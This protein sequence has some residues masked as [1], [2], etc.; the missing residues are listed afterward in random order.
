MQDLVSSGDLM[1]GLGGN[2]ER[3][4]ALDGLVRTVAVVAAGNDC[5]ADVACYTSSADCACK[6]CRDADPN[7]TA[8]MIAVADASDRKLATTMVV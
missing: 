1:P 8:A 3:L 5:I 6:G 4:V 7:G 2:N